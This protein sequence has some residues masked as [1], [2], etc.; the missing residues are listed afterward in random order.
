MAE[1]L[2]TPIRTV[3]DAKVYFQSMGCSHF[4]MTQQS[5]ERMK[6]YQAM[7][8]SKEQENKWRMESIDML[9]RL[10]EGNIK[11]EQIWFR[12]RLLIEIVQMIRTLDLYVKVLTV[13]QA[14]LPRI[15]KQDYT[16]VASSILDRVDP[17]LHKGFVYDAN[18]KDHRLGISFLRIARFLLSES[19]EETEVWK[20]AYNSLKEAERMIL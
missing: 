16:V 15:P 19:T 13:T 18:E 3:D 11:P 4:H 17:S 5:S 12:H 7:K 14:V 10:L 1:I 6:E 20:L 8:I 2:D 9:V